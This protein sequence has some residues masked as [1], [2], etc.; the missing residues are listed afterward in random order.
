MKIEE[1]E[2]KLKVLSHIVDDDFVKAIDEARR[3]LSELSKSGTSAEYDVVRIK[4]T[5]E[6]KEIRLFDGILIIIESN[7][8]LVF[9]CG[10]VEKAKEVVSR[11][12]HWFFEEDEIL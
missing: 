3:Y 2:N 6:G 4:K 10:S 11:I 8:N 12:G 1:V 5:A 9:K 7:G